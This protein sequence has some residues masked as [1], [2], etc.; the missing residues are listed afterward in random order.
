MIVSFKLVRLLFVLCFVY[1]GH[2]IGHAQVLPSA[3][4]N[5][6]AT[7]QAAQLPDP[8]TPAAVRQLMSKLSDAQVHELL[9]QRLDAEAKEKA[10]AKTNE[11]VL[12]V[13]SDAATDVGQNVTQGHTFAV[14]NRSR[15]LP[16]NAH[17][18]GRSRHYRPFEIFGHCR[19]FNWFGV[20]CQTSFERL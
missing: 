9:L 8:S 20:S 19:N 14:E 4:A 1:F 11:S 7:D 3:S 15:H 18:H 13:V 12:A 16:S 2:S 5:Q 10:S 17:F 6:S